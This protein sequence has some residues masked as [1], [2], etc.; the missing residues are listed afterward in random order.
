MVV[1]GASLPTILAKLCLLVKFLAFTALQFTFHMCHILPRVTGAILP[2]CSHVSAWLMSRGKRSTW[3]VCLVIFVAGANALEDWCWRGFAARIGLC[4]WRIERCC[5][6]WNVCGFLVSSR[7]FFG[8]AIQDASGF[9]S[10]V[11]VPTCLTSMTYYDFLSRSR[12]IA[13]L[14]GLS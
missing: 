11:V 6:Q 3:D 5:K 9:P 13:D 1:R 4:A 2:R 8:E 7:I 14:S 10:G 12:Y